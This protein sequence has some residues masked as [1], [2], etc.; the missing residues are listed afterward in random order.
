MNQEQYI[1]YQLTFWDHGTPP[2]IVRD[3]AV[4][5]ANPGC[6]FNR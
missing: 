1:Q 6:A 3:L 5:E 4:D 2:A